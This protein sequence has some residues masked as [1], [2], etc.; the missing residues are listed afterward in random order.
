MPKRSKL[1]QA[2]D[3][4]KGRDYEAEKQKKQVK[5]AEKRKRAKKGDDDKEEVETKKDDEEKVCAKLLRQKILTHF[6]FLS[7]QLLTSLKGPAEWHQEDQEGRY[8]FESKRKE[9]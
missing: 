7:V 9:G 4:H 3:D 2:L 6:V 1:L 5:A 8:H